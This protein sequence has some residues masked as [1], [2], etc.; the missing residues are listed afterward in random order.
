MQRYLHLDMSYLGAIPED[1][2]LSKAVMQQSPVCIS[3]MNAKSA[4]A[5]DDI[6]KTLMDIPHE[7][8]GFR[9]GMAGFFAN[10]I[11]GRYTG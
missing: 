1:S 6:A 4:K 8:Q 7:K 11:R 5:F 9:T 2:E 3:N 10:M